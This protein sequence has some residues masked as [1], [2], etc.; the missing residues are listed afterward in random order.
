MLAN[1][2]R[3]FSFIAPKRFYIIWLAILSMPDV[4]YSRNASCALNL[5]SNSAKRLVFPIVSVSA[6]RWFIKYIII[7]I[8]SP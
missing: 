7:E 1:L 3:P 6:L 5:M 8:Y 4:F 2:F